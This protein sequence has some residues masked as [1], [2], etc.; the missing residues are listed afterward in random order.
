MAPLT[1]ERVVCLASIAGAPS[2]VHW[3]GNVSVSPEEIESRSFTPSAEGYHQGEVQAFLARVA[4]Q[5]RRL[6][7]GSTPGA[8]VDPL[9]GT[10]DTLLQHEAR[11]DSHENRLAALS[12]RLEALL[13]QLEAA[14]T[15]LPTVGNG[16]AATAP[17]DIA[18]GAAMA[19]SASDDPIELSVDRAPLG[20]EPN[21]DYAP[22]AADDP[23]ILDD[24]ASAAAAHVP[25]VPRE[26]LAPAIGVID[27]TE[28]LFSD[29]AQDLLDGVLDDVLGSLADD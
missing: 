5:M 26:K 29:N 25:R 17:A 7:A 18:A 21:T 24:T 22:V 2:D 27:S 20:A 1:Q 16:V 6:Q 19:D 12:G 15:Q 8:I 3:E 13:T 4:Y 23:V 10:N 14:A 11:L 9:A 28:P